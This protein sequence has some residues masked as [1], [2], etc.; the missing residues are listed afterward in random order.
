MNDKKIGQDD[1][2]VT[3][4]IPTYNW[5]SV[6]RCAVASV[7]AQT[8]HNFELLVIGDHCT[9]DSADYILS[10]KDNRVHWRNLP[11]NSGSQSEPNNL[12]LSIARGRY[13]AYLGHDDLW[14]PSHL[15]RLF[16]HAEA[17]QADMVVSMSVMLGPPGSGVRVVAGAVNPG[18]NTLMGTPPPSSLMHRRDMIKDIGGWR[19]YRRLPAKLPPD[20]EFIRRAIAAGKTI[21]ATGQLTAFKFNSAWRRDSY[22]KRANDEQAAYLHRMATEPDF[23]ERE[24]TAIVAAMAFGRPSWPQG[25]PRA[26][27]LP[28]DA[29]PGAMVDM[30]RE[31]RGLPPNQSKAPD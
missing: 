14:H 29:P 28:D 4:I 1:I 23:I 26:E 27:E 24:L 6:L 2:D 5:S 25:I 19:D 9:D 30:W 21:G 15:Q 31:V 8:F 16:D 13:I 18:S 11:A 7:L 12:G 3:V 10:L 22:K 17:V 20:H